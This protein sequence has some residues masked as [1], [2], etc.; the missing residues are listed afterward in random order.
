MSKITAVYDRALEVLKELFPLK[1][2]IPYPYALERN[3]A[4]FMIDGYGLAVGPAAFETLETCGFVVNRQLSVVFTR[5]LHRT[6]SST[7]EVDQVVKGIM[8]DVYSVQNGFYNYSELDIPASIA[9]VD[10]VDVSSPEEVV[11]E[12]ESFLSMTASFNFWIYEKL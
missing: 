10:I 8:E 7:E 5:A 3:N 9:R 2:R 4:R 1:T 11:S 12:K 6:E